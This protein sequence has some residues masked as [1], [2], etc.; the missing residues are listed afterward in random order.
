MTRLGHKRTTHQRNTKDLANKINKA[1]RVI[2]IDTALVHLSA[3]IGKEIIVLLP[4]VS[5]ERWKSN[6]LSGNSYEKYCYMMRQSQ[7]NSWHNELSK[8]KSRILQ[9]LT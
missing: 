7:W 2:S 9:G 5:D 3:A 4:K 6:T 1:K 8:I